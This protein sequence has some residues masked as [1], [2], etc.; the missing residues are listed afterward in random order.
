LIRSHVTMPTNSYGVPGRG[1]PHAARRRLD[2]ER[3]TLLPRLRP[4]VAAMAMPTLLR[5]V[6]TDNALW[7]RTP[8]EVRYAGGMAYAHHR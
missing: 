1:G 2:P 4:Y 3:N 6:P 8:Y 5:H 7:E